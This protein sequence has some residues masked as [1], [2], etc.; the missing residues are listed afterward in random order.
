MSCKDSYCVGDHN[1]DVKAVG[2]YHDQ[3][4]CRRHLNRA[5]QN[6]HLREYRDS[7]PRCPT[8]PEKLLGITRWHG[9]P[10]LFCPQPT[11]DKVFYP[12]R[13]HGGLRTPAGSTYTSFCTWTQEIP[14]HVIKGE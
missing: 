9:A 5:L 14:Q 13:G 10:R 1:K 7:G 8:H 2:C 4:V 3:P 12:A 11:G 6:E